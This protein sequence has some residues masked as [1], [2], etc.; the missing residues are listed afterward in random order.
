MSIKIENHSRANARKKP[1][2]KSGGLIDFLNKDISFN[3]GR[4]ND[5]KKA[6]F[7][8][9][10]YTLLDAGLDLNAALKILD[11]ES[12]KKDKTNIYGTLQKDILQG[13]PLSV[14][15]KDSDKFSI[16]EYQSIRIGEETGMFAKMLGELKDHYDK[17]IKLRQQFIGLV[18]YPIIVILLTFGVL[19]FL[20][21]FVV[22]MFVG[23]LVQ[24][25]AELPAV[26]QFVL[27][28]SDFVAAW[29]RPF[30]IT[31]IVVGGFFYSQRKTD[32]YKKYSAMVLLRLPMV[33][34]MTRR[35]YLTRFCQSMALLT[36]SKI[37][38]VE[39]L[40]MTSEM[41][42]FYPISKALVNIKAGILKGRTLHECMLEEPIFEKRMISMVRVGEEVNRLDNV[43]TKLTEQYSDSIEAQTKV[44]KSVVEPIMIL[45]VGGIVALVAMAMI[46]P[47]FKMSSSMDF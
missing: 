9:D 12:P 18:T 26:T 30:F 6:Q 38:L 13:K 17:K 23:F 16:Y 20:M 10:M 27:D 43:F 14:A 44:L 46:L 3:G 22:P 33:G 41:V 29:I 42:D 45:T 1:V 24:M 4:F 19:I 15:M 35:I 21:N 11:E 7:Y 39:A 28:L 47:I 5:K 32:W 37:P 40:E 8:N 25:N 34:K 2:E 36:N 31:V